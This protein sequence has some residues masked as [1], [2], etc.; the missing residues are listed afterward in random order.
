MSE[1]KTPLITEEINGIYARLFKPL[2]YESS[3]LSRTITVPTNF[4]CDY[5]SIPLFK[6]TSKRAG[7]IHDY[8]CRNDL[9]FKIT[10]QKAASVYL[11]AMACRDKKFGKGWFK[12]AWL[13]FYRNMKVLV[14]RVAPGYFQKLP[15]DASFDEVKNNKLKSGRKK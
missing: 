11:E 9:P 6:S 5:E 2:V 12:K 13:L 4:V 7:V 10:K 1:F 15:V 3:L 14:V 8:L